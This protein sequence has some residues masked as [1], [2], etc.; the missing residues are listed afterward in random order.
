MVAKGEAVVVA[1]GGDTSMT[2]LAPTFLI[3]ATGG[4]RLGAN[5]EDIG[6]HTT[7]RSR[8]PYSDDA[9]WASKGLYGYYT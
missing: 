6:V 7:S 2:T 4:G 9:E 8:C 1:L 5:P 3:A